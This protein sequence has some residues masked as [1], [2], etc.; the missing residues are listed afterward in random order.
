MTPD[1][2]I[3]KHAQ[4]GDKIRDGKDEFLQIQ[5]HS[6]TWITKDC[7][8]APYSFFVF[9]Q[10]EIWRRTDLVK[11]NLRLDERW[12]L[13]ARY[14]PEEVTMSL[15]S[16]WEYARDDVFVEIDRRLKALEGK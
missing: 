6:I 2:F 15:R 11:G 10:P 3:K 8:V 13:V 12:A 1:E 14:E 7:L 4:P 5:N 9:Q 16:V